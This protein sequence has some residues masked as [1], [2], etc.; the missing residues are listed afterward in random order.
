MTSSRAKS[1]QK[2]AEQVSTVL[3]YFGFNTRVIYDNPAPGDLIKLV[4]EIDGALVTMPVD[5]ALCAPFMYNLSL[6]HI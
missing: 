3:E 5:I 4:D 6:I 1:L 2:V